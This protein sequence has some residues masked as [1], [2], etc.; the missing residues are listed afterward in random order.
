MQVTAE[1]L[2]TAARGVALWLGATVV[3]VAGL[4]AA[5]LLHPV[6]PNE[7]GVMALG[8]LLGALVAATAVWR[9]EPPIAALAWLLVNALL[10][11]AVLVLR[12]PLG[13][14]LS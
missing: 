11:G 2:T 4:S 3:V 5:D 8:F 1:P 14:A 6:F 12:V 7:A 13:L 9:R 10:A